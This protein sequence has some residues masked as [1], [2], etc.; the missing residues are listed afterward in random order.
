MT[1]TIGTINIWRYSSTQSLAYDAANNIFYLA[2]WWGDWLWV[3]DPD[4]GVLTRGP[5]TGERYITS[6]TFN[7]NNGLL[8]GA[9]RTVV[10]NPPPGS[11]PDTVILDNGIISINPANG[12][13][14]S[15]PITTEMHDI[16]V[17]W[18]SV[19][20]GTGIAYAFEAIAYDPDTNE[21]YIDHPRIRA[22]N[23]DTF[24]ERPVG[25]K[26]YR[27][28]DDGIELSPAEAIDIDI[29]PWSD[30]NLMPILPDRLTIVALLTTSISDGDSVDFDATQADPDSLR[31]GPD[32]APNIPASPF[33]MDVDNDLDIDA[34]FGFYPTD[35][36][37]SCQQEYDDYDGQNYVWLSETHA[38]VV[39][40]TYSGEHFGGGDF[41]EADS[42]IDGQHC[43]QDSC[44]P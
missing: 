36:G 8:Y 43:E 35:T 32:G 21:L 14:V 23:L 24:A 18:D 4:T 16:S 7:P 25:W 15:L 19:L 17:V 31:F 5:W 11:Q 42:S 22:I 12:A 28:H 10:D 6:L 44:H 30:E 40:Q 20:G 26:A 38:M 27:I 39:G 1:T 29:V 2:N 37:I 33:M 13:V 41:I 3:Y 34:V 9:R